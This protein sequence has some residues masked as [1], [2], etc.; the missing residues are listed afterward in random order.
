[1]LKTLLDTIGL[2]LIVLVAMAALH[3]LTH[4]LIGLCP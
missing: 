3:F 2:G 1:M 4:P